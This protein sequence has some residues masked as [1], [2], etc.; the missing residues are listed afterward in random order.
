MYVPKTYK[1]NVFISEIS[2][3]NIVVFVVRIRIL[4]FF[5]NK[6]SITHYTLQYI[7]IALNKM[8]NSDKWYMAF[9]TNFVM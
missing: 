5:P 8:G 6:I 2:N 7:A 1:K 4:S 3:N 9:L